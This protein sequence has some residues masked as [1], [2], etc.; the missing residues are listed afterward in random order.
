MKNYIIKGLHDFEDWK[1]LQKR[2]SKRVEGGQINL[3]IIYQKCF[4]LWHDHVFSLIDELKKMSL[5][6]NWVID[7]T[8]EAS[9]DNQ[10]IAILKQK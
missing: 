10:Y 6:M 1:E 5:Y 3:R 2:A 4:T 8:L 9:V 7:E